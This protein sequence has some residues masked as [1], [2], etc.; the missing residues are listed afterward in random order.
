MQ[1]GRGKASSASSSSSTDSK[2][3]SIS[4]STA[5]RGWGAVPPVA[6]VSVAAP[7]P[8]TNERKLVTY[9]FVS[10]I[11]QLVVVQ[12]RDGSVLEGLFQTA[13][14]AAHGGFV[15]VLRLV[16]PQ[17]TAF[18]DTRQQAKLHPTLYVENKNDKTWTRNTQP[19][20]EFRRV[21]SIDVIQMRTFNHSLADPANTNS[22]NTQHGFA[23]DTQIS[24]GEVRDREL[25][26]WQSD[27]QD[28]TNN[29]VSL[30]LD[31]N[32]SKTKFDQ[33]AVHEAMT[34]Q[35]S[36]F[37]FDDYTTPLDK[38]SEFYKMHE[39]KADSIAR[40]ILGSQDEGNIHL[41]QERGLAVELDD[42][43][44]F[45]TVQRDGK[46]TNNNAS[47]SA[48]SGTKSGKYQIPARRAAGATNPSN[49]KPE[50]TNNST[51]TDKSK[52]EQKKKE[53]E[54]AKKKKEEEE[55]KKKKEEEEAKKKKE[56]EEAAATAAAA[57]AK[58]EQEKQEKEAKEKQEKEA[59]DK[60]DKDVKDKEDKKTEAK[61]KFK[62]NVN[63]KEYV[64]PSFTPS[65]TSSTTT[66]A[67]TNPGSVQNFTPMG[68]VP[69]N[70]NPMAVLA[71]NGNMG[72]GNG[73]FNG[74]P[75]MNFNPAGVAFPANGFSGQ[76]SYVMNPQ[77]AGGN[78]YPNRIGLGVPTPMMNAGF[79]PQGTFM[80]AGNPPVVPLNM[81]GTANPQ[82]FAAAQFPAHLGQNGNMMQGRPVLSI[83]QLQNMA[84]N[85][86]PQFTGMPPNV[87]VP[88]QPQLQYQ[89]MNP[90]RQY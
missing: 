36:S 34:K 47:S 90:N 68:G 76:A 35:K 74:N 4:S 19:W 41:K 46:T 52:E 84:G 38:N 29:G 65:S 1:L 54:E 23:T 30:T 88:L 14:V 11:G 61:S 70:M 59:K 16:Q 6:A 21:D 43:D 37:N 62:F 71:M 50:T 22:S 72:M 73:G 24:R 5:P 20:E 58:E 18:A 53:E 63:A 75:G 51:A 45:S 80:G 13:E 33:F 81:M 3:S 77:F 78:Q 67:T 40:E 31:D 17:P 2:S 89:P 57:K 15:Y 55:A 25:Q 10:L 83:Q 49:S 27:G 32:N 44:L 69:N 86:N 8:A 56:E 28:N 39:A 42:D 64:P 79:V 85:F 87:A 82:Q 48:S 60:E 26:K 12:L 9:F 7:T 66:T